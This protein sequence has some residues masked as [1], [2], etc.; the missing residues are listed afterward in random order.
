MALTLLNSEA[1]AGSGSSLALSAGADFQPGDLRIWHVTIAAGA[2]FGTTPTG[3]TKAA[4]EVFTSAGRVGV[5]HRVLEAGDTSFTLPFSASTQATRVSTTVRGNYD[6]ASPVAVTSAGSSTA[7]TS[8]PA[9][10]A[11]PDRAGTL[12]TFHRVFRTT[13]ANT[14]TWTTLPSGMTQEA[15]ARPS[16]AAGYLVTGM[17]Q[18]ITA[19]DVAVPTGARTAV[20]SGSG[21]WVSSTL[22]IRETSPTVITLAGVPSA[23]AV[24]TPSVQTTVTPT[25]VPSAEAVGTPALSISGALA[26]AGV[27]SAEAVGTPTLI[28]GSVSGAAVGVPSAEAVGQPRLAMTVTPAAVPSAEAVG[29]PAVAAGPVAVTAA[30]VPTAEVVP[31]PVVVVG[32]VAI[33]AS[34]VPSAEVVPA[35][36]LTLRLFAIGVPSGETVG[37][38]T[39]GIGAVGIYLTGVPT[40]EMVGFPEVTITLD[41]VVRV[42]RRRLRSTPLYEVVVM[43]RIA[44]PSGPPVLIDVD[45]IEWSTLTWS[46]TNSRP[47]GLSMSFQRARVT[48]AVRLHLRSPDRLATELWTLR[49]GVV[50]QAGPL[51]GGAPQ[52]DSLRLEAGGLMTYLELMLVEQSLRFNQVDQFTI[53]ATL[54]DQWQNNVAPGATHGHF[55]IDTSRVGLSGKLRDH[56]YERN[57]THWV[58]RRIQEL[59]ERRDGFDAEI[60]PASRA[61]QLWYRGKGVD[62]SSGED[63]I[64]F[65]RR[66]VDD[67]SGMFA[68][69]PGDLASDAYGSASA[70]G[71]DQALWSQ[72]T[73]F[74]L[75]AA[76]GRSAV[77][78]SWSDVLVQSTLDDHV[79]ALLDARDQ[80]LRTPGRKVRVTPDSDLASYDV[81]DTVL[82]ELDD[83]LG[84]GGAYRIR[85]RT[86]SVAA[87][88]EESVDLEFV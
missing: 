27:A 20:A 80:P 30:G 49:N 39:L 1:L 40:G 48:S 68:L 70:A 42:G 12:L 9:P 6:A 31:S 2:T 15:W 76:Y 52:G 85:S 3:V 41:P 62:R 43:H 13:G 71:S 66:N 23:E 25:G 60:D 26:P 69:G 72:Q 35:P 63:A 51:L 21:A 11:T 88:G 82:Y 34:G 65:D 46:S 79:G 17:S 16:V 38:P 18:I 81:G 33:G 78:G 37:T 50:V 28:V 64:V 32:A 86:V 22:L 83:L 24:G 19:G 56:T 75:R 84:I 74:D 87:S 4:D 67:G 77:A 5:F 45:A 29:V 53:A 57:E 55:G 47:Q 8:V 54:I 61:L 36:K 7:A 73:N 59:G 44:Q 14:S 58:A 10:T